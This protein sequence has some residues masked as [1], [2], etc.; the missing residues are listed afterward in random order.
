MGRHMGK[1]TAAMQAAAAAGGGDS[2][3]SSGDGSEVLEATVLC[4]V[5]DQCIHLAFWSAPHRSAVAALANGAVAL[6][7]CCG[8]HVRAAER[9]AR[10]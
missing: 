5:V 9:I 8:L 7:L 1:T 3:S 2:S 4:T 10:S 6:V